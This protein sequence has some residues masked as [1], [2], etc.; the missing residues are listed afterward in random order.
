M[1]IF[2]FLSLMPSTCLE[3]PISYSSPATGALEFFFLVSCFQHVLSCQFQHCWVPTVASG[4]LFCI[5][6]LV[7]RTNGRL[8]N[9]ITALLHFVVQLDQGIDEEGD[10]SIR[11]GRVVELKPISPT[12]KY[13]RRSLL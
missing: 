11:L 1:R 4:T 2:F 8:K 9:N 6:I 10:P 13:K 5:I 7:V 3:L 12:I